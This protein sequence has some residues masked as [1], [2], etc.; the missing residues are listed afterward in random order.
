MVDV[1]A[2]FYQIK[3]LW[4]LEGNY[5]QDLVEHKM[6]V[7]IF[8]ATSSP[9]VATFALQCATDFQGEFGQ[10]TA[11]TVKKKIYIDDCLK[12]ILSDEDIAI[13]L[14]AELRNMLAKGGF[15]L[16]KWSSNSRKLLNSIPDATWIGTACQWKGHWASSGVSNQISSSLRS[17]LKNDLTPGEAYSFMSVPSSTQWALLRQWS[18]LQKVS[19]RIYVAKNMA[20]MNNCQITSTAGKVDLK[21]LCE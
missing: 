7:H 4:W 21:S 12:A 15:R 16:T 13:T 18:C 9:A 1:D 19:C 5:E 8:G 3:F 6:L 17:T 10:E 14:C 11:K 2:M 20:G